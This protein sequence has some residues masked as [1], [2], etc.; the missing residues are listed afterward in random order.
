MSSDPSPE[1]TPAG[2]GDATAS[3]TTSTRSVLDDGSGT[4]KPSSR[5]PSI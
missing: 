3:H 5:R 1:V 4:G 2:R